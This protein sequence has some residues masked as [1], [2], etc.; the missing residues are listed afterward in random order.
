MVQYCT[1]CTIC[2]LDVLLLITVV[3]IRNSFVGRAAT[4]AIGT[5]TRVA[6]A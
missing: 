3:F 6:R 1:H 5:A 2:L 4:N